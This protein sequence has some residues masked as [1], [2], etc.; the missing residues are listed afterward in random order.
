MEYTHYAFYRERKEIVKIVEW[1]IEG[2]P[3]L[4]CIV[5]SKNKKWFPYKDALIRIPKEFRAYIKQDTA[6]H[7]LD[8]TYQNLHFYED[9]EFTR[10]KSEESLWFEVVEEDFSFCISDL[11][12]DF[13]SIIQITP[14]IKT[15][16]AATSTYV[17]PPMPSLEEL[18][19]CMI[20]FKRRK[21]I[22]TYCE[23]FIGVATCHENDEFDVNSGVAIAYTRA[24]MNKLADDK[25]QEEKVTNA[26]IKIGDCVKIVNAGMNC[27]TYLSWVFE[28]IRDYELAKKY[29]YD[30][31]L[32]D[33]IDRFDTFIVKY[34]DDTTAYIQNMRNCSCRVIYLDGIALVSE[35]GK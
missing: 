19:K 30:N 11:D 6:F 8:N 31:I 14:T 16:P 27:S 15:V 34:V 4:A 29:A 26:K 33:S 5:T 9:I 13:F 10:E 17:I 12:I 2:A 1:D 32:M 22:V 7:C 20:S 28:N 18:A 35:G 25:R 23:K 24:Y 21:T 3:E